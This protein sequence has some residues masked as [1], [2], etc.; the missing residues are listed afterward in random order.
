MTTADELLTPDEV[1]AWLRTPVSTLAYWRKTKVG[2]S[3]IK[4]TRRVVYRRSDVTAW[5]DGRV[6]EATGG[7]A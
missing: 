5:L 4:L 2:P 6:S 3:F 7:A 1:A